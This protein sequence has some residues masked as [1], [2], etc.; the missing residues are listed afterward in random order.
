MFLIEERL[1]LWTESNEV[2]V[3][4]LL[5]AGMKAGELRQLSQ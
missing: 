5:D 1:F 2:R 3:R 4:Y